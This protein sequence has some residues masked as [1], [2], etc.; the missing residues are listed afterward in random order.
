MR[1]PFLI[2]FLFLIMFSAVCLARKHPIGFKV[3]YAGYALT[4]QSWVGGKQDTLHCLAL[5]LTNNSN[6]EIKLGHMTCGWPRFFEEVRN[7]ID[8]YAYRCTANYPFATTLNPGQSCINYGF[9]L[10]VTHDTHSLQMKYYFYEGDAYVK[11]WDQN[12]IGIKP[13]EKKIELIP[14][15]VF[16]NLFKLEPKVKIDYFVHMSFWRPNEEIFKQIKD[17]NSYDRY[18]VKLFRT[19]KRYSFL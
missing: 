9:Y 18:A 1:S 7:N 15:F 13:G 3:C 19:L 12:S 8:Y 16:S 5:I 10:D 14:H 6:Q 17:V 11:C 4:E 2:V